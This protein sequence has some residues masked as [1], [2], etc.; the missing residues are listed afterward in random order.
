M[1][2][3]CI[4]LQRWLWYHQA[5]VAG[6]ILHRKAAVGMIHAPLRFFDTTPSGVILGRFSSDTAIIEK[7]LRW[8]FE[9]TVRII[10]QVVVTLVFLLQ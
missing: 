6:G 9:N 5:I 8:T 7:E 2:L 3:A 4:F 10:L 1:T